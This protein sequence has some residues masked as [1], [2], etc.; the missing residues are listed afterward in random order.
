MRYL[1]H[2]LTQES[3][4]AGFPLQ[5]DSLR[6]EGF[7]HTSYKDQVEST[8][9]LHFAGHNQLQ[10]V[11]IDPRRTAAPIKEES[12]PRGPM[13]HVFG[14]IDADA[15]VD[16]FPL[17]H[18]EQ[19]P[20]LVRGNKFAL[21]VF[22]GITWLD[23]IGVYD[24]LSRLSSMNF[25]PESQCCWISLGETSLPLMHGASVHIEQERK[26]LDEFDVLVV[27]GGMGTR[28]LEKQ[29]E[30][31][32]Y[33]QTFPSNRLTTSVCTGSLLLGAAGRLRGKRATTHHREL[34]RLSEFGVLSTEATR[35]VEDGQLITAGGVSCTIDLGLAL[36]KRLYSSDI[37]KQIAKQMQLPAGFGES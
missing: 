31:I 32:H 5:P 14:T 22:P 20:D 6:T 17:E 30:I 8:A 19:Q 24:V 7:I 9:R 3:K 27:P 25:D 21:L 26:P 29:P 28:I 23:I 35:L 16:S 33:L 11:R 36:V 1:F 15:I 12:T 18:L 4:G 37:A 2:I 13:P 10:I 34:H